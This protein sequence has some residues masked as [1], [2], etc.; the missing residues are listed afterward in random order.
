MSYLDSYNFSDKFRHIIYR[1]PI[2]GFKDIN[3]FILNKKRQK[4]ENHLLLFE[5]YII[6]TFIL[7]VVY[8][9]NYSEVK[10]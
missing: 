10:K 8:L 5:F 1:I 6:I 7:I 4:N 2:Y 9:S 3:Y